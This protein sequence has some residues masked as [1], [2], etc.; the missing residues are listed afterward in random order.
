MRARGAVSA[1]IVTALCAADAWAES[2]ALVGPEI[3][4]AAQWSGSFTLQEAAKNIRIRYASTHCAPA[5]QYAR[6]I[7]AVR[8]R[9]GKYSNVWMTVQRSKGGAVVANGFTPPFDLPAGAYEVSVE[10]KSDSGKPQKVAACVGIG[11]ACAE[12]DAL[13][14]PAC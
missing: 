8:E 5:R 10:A 11:D 2:R 12:F 9:A 13:Q 14:P 1:I 6:T 7:L 3:V 4:Q